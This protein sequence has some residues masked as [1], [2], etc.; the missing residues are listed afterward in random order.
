MRYCRSTLGARCVLENNSIQWPVKQGYIGMY[1]RMKELG[2]PIAF[3][4][5]TRAKVGDLRRALEWAVDQG[6]NSVELF[7]RYEE[8]PVSLLTIF[9]RA[10]KANAV[11]SR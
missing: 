3:Q 1:A 2:P 6:A 8:Y 4:T 10:L 9:D 7:R 11:M 5:D